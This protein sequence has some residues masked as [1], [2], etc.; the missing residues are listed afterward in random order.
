MPRPSGASSRAELD[1]P[2][3]PYEEIDRL[4]DGATPLV[5]RRIAR[6][7]RKQNKTA[8][9]AEGVRNAKEKESK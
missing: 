7:M 5:V 3:I 1:G 4:L 6:Q 9:R 2:P 8:G